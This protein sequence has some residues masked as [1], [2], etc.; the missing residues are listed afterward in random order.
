MVAVLEDSDVQI[1][2]SFPSFI[3]KLFLESLLKVDTGPSTG[4]RTVNCAGMAPA[5]KLL[6]I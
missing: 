3:I 4:D 1:H 2:S 5:L 6:I